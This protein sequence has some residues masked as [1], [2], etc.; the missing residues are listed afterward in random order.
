MPTVIRLA[1]IDEWLCIFVLGRSKQIETGTLGDV[2][3]KSGRYVAMLRELQ[4]LCPHQES[5]TPRLL[6][7]CINGNPDSV[8]Q[9]DYY[10]SSDW[11]S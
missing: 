6:F 10:G 4:H 8:A 7:T 3:Q 2:Y 11:D 5:L 1:I 9:G